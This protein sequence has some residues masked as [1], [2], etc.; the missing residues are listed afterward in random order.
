MK[1]LGPVGLT[2]LG[3]LLGNWLGLPWPALL[4]YTLLA[5]LCTTAVA[6][7]Q[8]L[9]PQDSHD[10]LLWWGELLKR[11]RPGSRPGRR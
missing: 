8:I 4:A 3:N 2:A 9:V 6:L 7:A 10:K 1:L 5:A 11:Q